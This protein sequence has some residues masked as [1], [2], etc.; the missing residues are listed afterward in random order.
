M[1]WIILFAVLLLSGCG[2]RHY[3]VEAQED[4]SIIYL[5]QFANEGFL[6]TPN[7][8]RGEYLSLGMITIERY[9]EARFSRAIL[10]SPGREAQQHGWYWFSEEIQ[11]TEAVEKAYQIARDLG[12]DA[13]VNVKIERMIKKV[14]GDHTTLGQIEGLKLTALAIKRK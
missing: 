12:A 4:T 8:Y 11:G 7:E 13:L 9:P 10:S 6:V 14:I 3:K 2:Y 1:R 5:F